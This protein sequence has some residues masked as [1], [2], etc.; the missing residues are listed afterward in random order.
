MPLTFGEDNMLETENIA[1]ED[2]TRDKEYD[3][4][5]N[6]DAES[7]KKRRKFSLQNLGM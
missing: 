7:F 4:T 5:K 2:Y 3:C 1:L 6:K